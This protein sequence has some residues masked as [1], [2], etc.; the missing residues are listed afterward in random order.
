MTKHQFPYAQHVV[1][2]HFARQYLMEVSN[3]ILYI[4]GTISLNYPARKYFSLQR[5]KLLGKN[6][7]NVFI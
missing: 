5:H 6:K 3:I 1:N 7:K 4:N 2:E